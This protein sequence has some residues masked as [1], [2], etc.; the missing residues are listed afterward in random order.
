MA[1]TLLEVKNLQTHF[2]TRSGVAKAV[3]DVSF[4]LNESETLGLVGES[5]CGKSVTSLSIMR[6]I[7][8]PGKIVGGEIL[9]K[10]DD[11]LD[12]DQEDL[13]KLRGGQ[14]AMIFQDPMTSLN[15]VLPIGF[16]IA[17]AV[18]AHLKMDDTAAMNRAA[19]MLD[20][21]RIPEARRRLKDYP[22]QFSGGMRQRVMIAIALS[23]NPQI[24]I[25]DEPTTALDVTIQAQ[26][27]DLMK[28]LATEFRTATLLITHD[29][30]VVAG[31]C[32]RVCVMYAGRVVE[33]APTASIFK[34]PAHPYTQA[35]LAAVPR[36]EQQRG[37]RLA[38]IGGQ[39][40]NLVNLP[41]GCPFAP[42][43]RKAQPRCR[44][45]LPL[46][47]NVGPNQRAACFYPY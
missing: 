16:Q 29:L 7:S 34:T 33:T 20:R 13:Y 43:C 42:R 44:Q 27:L 45:E 30:G 6:L 40:P 21:V 32:D 37:E 10:G 17:E 3:E 25:A 26:V 23:C 31:T 14:I 19:E 46:L 41:P 15:P 11:V 38:A 12:M 18:K 28:G 8:P 36:P 9:Y 4:T 39:P 24:L 35:L 22:H 5:G 2:Y 1:E 47:E